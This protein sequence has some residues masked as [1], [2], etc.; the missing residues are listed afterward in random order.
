V[1]SRYSYAE[2]PIPPVILHSY[3]AHITETSYLLH[4]W[5]NSQQFVTG[6]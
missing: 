6:F 1:D 5:L 4:C 2:L 3:C